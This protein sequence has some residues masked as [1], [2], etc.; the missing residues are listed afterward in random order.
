MTD[1][2]SVEPLHGMV[3]SEWGT[4]LPDRMTHLREGKKQISRP[5]SKKL[6]TALHYF[7]LDGLQQADAARKAGLTPAALCQAL[8]RPH[9]HERIKAIRADSLNREGVRSVKR[10]IELRDQDENKTVALDASRYLASLAG[11]SAPDKRGFSANSGGA[12][13]VTMILNKKSG[14]GVRVTKDGDDT[15]VEVV[16]DADIPEE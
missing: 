7:A 16:T 6:D 3:V 8:K 11:I 1:E 4:A 10:V 2:T 12:R 9:I 15:H 14:T 13:L 5:I